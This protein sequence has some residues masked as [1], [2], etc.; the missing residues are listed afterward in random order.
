MRRNSRPALASVLVVGG[1]V[2]FMLAVIGLAIN[3]TEFL[4]AIYMDLA[5][6]LPRFDYSI[7]ESGESGNATF[8]TFVQMRYVA[9]GVAG[10]ALLWA[11]LARM[12]E[13]TGMISGG[14]SN[15]IMS[16]CIIFIILFM[17]FPLLWDGAVTVVE[18][19]SLWVL[20]PAYT[21]NPETPCPAEWSDEDI[22]QKYNESP[23][24]RGDAGQISDAVIFC[25]P[26]FKIRYVFDQMMGYTEL[27]DTKSAYL[28]P[29][30]PFSAL[31][32]DIQNFSESVLVNTFLGLTKALVTINIL[33]MAFVIGILADLL[34][35]MIIAAF[36]LILMLTL[37]PKVDA[38]ANRFLDAL[39]I[40]FLLPLLSA[41][42]I[43][44]G[45]GFIAQI[46]TGPCV[47][48]ACDGSGV[49][50]LY[51]WISSLG[52]VFFAVA[53]PVMF[54]PLLGQVTQVASRA[55]TGA[56]HTAGAATKYGVRSMADSKIFKPSSK[57]DTTLSDLA[58]ISDKDS[59]T[60]LSDLAPL[61]D[62]NS[63]TTKSNP[64]KNNTQNKRTQGA[65]SL[66]DIVRE[67]LKPVDMN[68][69]TSSYMT[70]NY[71]PREQYQMMQNERLKSHNMKSSDVSVDKPLDIKGEHDHEQ[72]VNEKKS[73]PEKDD[74]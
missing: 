59:S 69:V 41:V 73:E 28:T 54:V 61:S 44:V 34:V 43:S 4:D 12:L 70:P 48:D 38:V 47:G 35:G 25:E 36:P 7:N 66:K 17:A 72:S 13:G 1:F 68:D 3:L 18:G 52:V 40:L 30:D 46:G 67:E 55:I 2:V 9:G 53:L 32:T 51:A 64:P 27:Q 57:E 71:T 10:M 49:M 6:T 5:L 45:A 39:P 63:G 15:A 58:P 11:G 31:T 22:I 29:D 50:T 21:F 33:L 24:R 65:S 74:T 19:A 23:Y 14:T 37:I 20:N 16:R 60:T 42:V 56:V 26:Q 8:D 62:D